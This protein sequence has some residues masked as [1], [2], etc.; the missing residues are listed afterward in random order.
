MGTRLRPGYG[1]GARIERVTTI[2]AFLF[3][4]GVLVFVHELGHFLARAPDRRPRAHVFARL[5]PQAPQDQARRHR[6][7]DQR[8]SARRLREDGR[9]KRGGRAQRRARRVPVEDQVAAFPG[10]HHGSRDEPPAR[11]HRD[12]RRAGAGRRGARVS[13][14]A[15]GGRRRE[16]RFAGGEGGPAARRSDPDGGR[17]RGPPRG[18]SSTSRSARGPAAT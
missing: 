8:D 17:R 1:P 18:T 12:G 13:R 2:L 14:R 5:R 3:V 10:A 9:R 6:I 7:R 11:G 16:A 15:A 4:L